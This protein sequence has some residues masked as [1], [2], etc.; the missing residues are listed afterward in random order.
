[1][2]SSLYS[3]RVSNSFDEKEFSS[4]KPAAVQITS[5]LNG[6]KWLLNDLKSGAIFNFVNNNKNEYIQTAKDVYKLNQNKDL[7]KA[8]SYFDPNFRESNSILDEACVLLGLPVGT[9]PE[10]VG[11]AWKKQKFLALKK[12]DKKEEE[13][14]NDLQQKLTSLQKSNPDLK[15]F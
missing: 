4:D 12:R 10:E 11:K 7:Y 14:L 6:C 15:I 9:E 13:K 8:I 2:R 5:I 1:M 3:A